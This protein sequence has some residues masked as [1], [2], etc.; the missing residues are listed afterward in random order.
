MWKVPL[1]SITVVNAKYLTPSHDTISLVLDS[2]EMTVY[3]KDKDR[4]EFL[5]V[6]EYV[7]E[8]E[9]FLRSAEMVK[10]K[11]SI[12]E[13]PKEPVVPEVTSPVET[14]PAILPSSPPEVVEASAPQVPVVPAPEPVPSSTPEPAP[15]SPVVESEP[16]TAVSDVSPDTTPKVEEVQAPTTVPAPVVVEVPVSQPAGYPTPEKASE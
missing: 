5:L 9:P 7:G 2:G 14:A 12:P 10:K 8:I 4:K 1:N 3:H 6:E 16:Q 13:A 11:V 15:L